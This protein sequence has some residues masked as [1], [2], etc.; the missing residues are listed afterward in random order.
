MKILARVALGHDS[1]YPNIRH[2]AFDHV[3]RGVST[4]KKVF[5]SFHT[6]SHPA[7]MFTSSLG[8]ILVVVPCSSPRHLSLGVTGILCAYP[9]CSILSYIITSCTLRYAHTGA[10][11]RYAL[12][13]WEKRRG[14]NMR[15]NFIEMG[16]IR[17]SRFNDPQH[18]PIPEHIV[19]HT[20]CEQKSNH[21]SRSPAHG[22]F[23]SACTDSICFCL[24][25][26]RLPAQYQHHV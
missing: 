24:E 25:G 3:Q 2:H 16:F 13:R 11:L 12:V 18:N 20:Q 9:R 19:R 6:T 5:S 1:C 26:S 7:H 10:F 17:K 23:T 21:S 14:L 8:G 4:L 15:R 22:R